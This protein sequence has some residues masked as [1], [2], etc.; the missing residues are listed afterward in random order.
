MMPAK[1]CVQRNSRLSHSLSVG[2]MIMMFGERLAP[3]ISRIAVRTD[4]KWN[5]VMLGSV[6]DVEYDSHL[7][8]ETGDAKRREIRFCIKDKAIRAIG[9]RT[10]HKEERLYAPVGV[11]TCM[12]QL[13]PGFVNVLYFEADSN[14]AGGRPSRSVEYMSRGGS[15]F[16]VRI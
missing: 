15:H 11:G 6:V 16:F 10:V 3:A 12:A 8:I 14:A 4:Q 13:G 7:R 9:H 2:S 1:T 5:V